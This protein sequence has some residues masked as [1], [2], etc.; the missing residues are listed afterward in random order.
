MRERAEQ[1]HEIKKRQV[2]QVLRIDINLVYIIINI[3]ILYFLLKKFL[4]KPLDNILAKRQAKVDGMLNNAST[5]ESE[6]IQ[7]KEKYENQ[8]A[9]VQ[10]E[11]DQMVEQAKKDA[12]FEHDKILNQANDEAKSIV[13]KARETVALEREKAMR[14][15]EAEVAGLAMTAAEKILR[16]K[17]GAES[18]QLLY[19]QFLDKAG[20]SNDTD[21]N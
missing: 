9:A 7:L 4:I 1:L 19:D 13:G 12:Q 16:D 5:K 10:T 3:L 17:S 20:D 6:A 18:D 2:R 11:S 8:I 14:E 21:L 15:M